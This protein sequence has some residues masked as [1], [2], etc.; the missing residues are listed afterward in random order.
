MCF[1]ALLLMHLIC[2]ILNVQFDVSEVLQEFLKTFQFRHTSECCV[3]F[4]IKIVSHLVQQSN[5]AY[6]CLL[7]GNTHEMMG[8]LCPTD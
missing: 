7:L 4:R 5:R 1:N 8:Y 2:N 3:M 6:L